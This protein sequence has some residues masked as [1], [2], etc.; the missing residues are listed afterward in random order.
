MGRHKKSE[1]EEE[2]DSA[3]V[4]KKRPI[5]D[6]TILEQKLLESTKLAEQDLEDSSV[7]PKEIAEA[8]ARTDHYQTTI[9]QILDFK[10]SAELA[11]A[12]LN[13]Q[14]FHR[15][16]EMVILKQLL[17][18]TKLIIDSYHSR[19]EAAVIK[20]AEVDKIKDDVLR[21]SEEMSLQGTIS[22]YNKSIGQAI[23][24][25][26]DLIYLERVSG[27]RTLGSSK[28]SPASIVFEEAPEGAKP[29]A[30]ASLT[31]YPAQDL[32]PQR[33]QLSK[34]E[35]FNWSNTEDKE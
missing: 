11:T 25:L 17:S 7:A 15:K 30:P 5:I 31:E 29:L 8:R 22:Y 6:F 34:E 27:G 33:K 32:K 19:I 35:I 12:A 10:H 20:L 9:N 18:S 4:Y 14:M 21:L 24:N 28:Q 26:K 3:L 1:I 2:D 23:K 16:D 13:S